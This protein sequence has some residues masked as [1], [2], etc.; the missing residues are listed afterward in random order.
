MEKGRSQFEEK[1]KMNRKSAAK[2]RKCSSRLYALSLSYA[3][4]VLGHVLD[5]GGCSEDGDRVVF[6]SWC[7]CW[8]KEK[9]FLSTNR[10]NAEQHSAKVIG[11][12]LSFQLVQPLQHTSCTYPP[13]SSSFFFLF[14][15][16]CDPR[17]HVCSKLVFP[18]KVTQIIRFHPNRSAC[19]LRHR[20]DVPTFIFTSEKT[21]LL[22]RIDRLFKCESSEKSD[23]SEW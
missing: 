14:R 4:P 17:V 16:T 5:R 12:S 20:F 2:P 8:T 1:L 19:Q 13:L 22:K 18:P 21:E 23:L 10:R 15:P 7:R 11:R 6:D 3:Q 9:R